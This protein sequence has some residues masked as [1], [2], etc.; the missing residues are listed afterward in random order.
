MSEMAKREGVAL[1]REN[2]DELLYGGGKCAGLAVDSWRFRFA[3][4]N[5]YQGIVSFEFPVI[6]NNKGSVSDALMD[7][8]KG[9][10]DQKYGSNRSN[11][12]SGEHHLETWSFPETPD[13]RG[14][15]L[16]QLNY[17]WQAGVMSLTYTNLYYQSLGN[18]FK[19]APGDL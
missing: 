12:S 3:N 17:N 14:E 10:L 7:A 1:L 9:L 6:F 5:F 13:S 2:A 19:V 11:D 16:I 15:K 4:G 8:I 18:P